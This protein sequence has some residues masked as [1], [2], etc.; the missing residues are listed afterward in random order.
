MKKTLLED[1]D[2]FEKTIIETFGLKKD[3]LNELLDK[4]H[5][6][7]SIILNILNGFENEDSEN[8]LTKYEDIKEV[9]EEFNLDI[10]N[11]YFDTSV[12]ERFLFCLEPL[13]YIYKGFTIKLSYYTN[14]RVL[15]EY[16]R[17]VCDKLDNFF[18]NKN[19]L[20]SSIMNDCPQRYKVLLFN[21]F[22]YGMDKESR[23]SE[24]ETLYTS[25]DYGANNLSQELILEAFSQEDNTAENTLIELP[26]DIM[27]GDYVTI[28]RGVGSKSKPIDRAYAWTTDIEVAKFFATR[29]INIEKHLDQV[30]VYKLR[31]HKD[32][33]IS[34]VGGVEKEV[35]IN[36]DSIESYLEKE[37]IEEVEFDKTKVYKLPESYI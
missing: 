16:I 10:R 15:M 12:D 28:Y 30:K 18:I 7:N 22:A 13:I 2:I 31:V 21:I 37:L 34:Y 29:L 8:Y 5:K 33:I 11:I 1:I 4:N 3:C 17:R 23:I 20:N 9:M 19:P 24:C 27:D 25:S 36:T 35:L 26:A 32:D 6:H 14:I